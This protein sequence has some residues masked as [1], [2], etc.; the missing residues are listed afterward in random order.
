VWKVAAVA[1]R[2][3]WPQGA[4]RCCTLCSRQAWRF[5]GFA[6]ESAACEHRCLGAVYTSS[7]AVCWTFSLNTC[8]MHACTYFAQPLIIVHY[9]ATWR[10]RK[11][12]AST[13]ARS[14]TRVAMKQSGDKCVM[15]VAVVQ[16]PRVSACAHCCMHVGAFFAQCSCT[17]TL[18]CFQAVPMCR[19][20]QC[21]TCLAQAQT[22]HDNYNYDAVRGAHSAQQQVESQRVTLAAPVHTWQGPCL[23]R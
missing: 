5:C 18:G 21:M 23:C 4:L 15:L 2:R 8:C 17:N 9:S 3:L 16:K 13:A 19:Q 11:L 6:D 1:V 14:L 10:K 22:A 12:L 7:R 20:C